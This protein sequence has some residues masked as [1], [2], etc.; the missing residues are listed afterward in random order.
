MWNF[1][2]PQIDQAAAQASQATDSSVAKPLYDQAQLRIVDQAPNLFLANQDQ[3][4]AY[5]P[6]VKN[7]QAMPDGTWQGLIQTSLEP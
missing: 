3:F 5:T 1:S 2:D 6:K 7:Y 4:L